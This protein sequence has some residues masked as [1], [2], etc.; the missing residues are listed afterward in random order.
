MS[1]SERGD[2]IA[3]HR[4]K[5]L[6]GDPRHMLLQSILAEVRRPPSSCSPNDARTHVVLWPQLPP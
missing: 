4:R 6:L 2:V 3:D 1:M 5:A